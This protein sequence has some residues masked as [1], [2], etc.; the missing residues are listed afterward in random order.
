MKET[1]FNHSSTH[2]SSI[3]RYLLII[4]V[5]FVVVFT[6]QAQSNRDEH[7]SCKKAELL[8]KYKS[9]K[10]SYLTD[11]LSLTPDEAYKFWP[12]YNQYADEKAVLHRKIVV[13]IKAQKSSERD[14]DASLSKMFAYKEEEL[15]IEKKYTSKFKEA[16]SSEKI[17]K[18][19]YHEKEFKKKLVEKMNS[20]MKSKRPDKD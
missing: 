8:E 1:S 16:I 9:Q 15:A 3:G 13:D 11:K 4:V 14:P 20:R 17:L 5:V 10:I 18:L 7:D 2:L 19:F 12:F 6:T